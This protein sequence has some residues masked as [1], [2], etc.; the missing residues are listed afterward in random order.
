LAV[1]EIV[2][3]LV[4]SSEDDRKRNSKKKIR[5]NYGFVWV[6]PSACLKIF[7]ASG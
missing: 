5:I 3:G 6:L 7:S 2:V 4:D 1:G